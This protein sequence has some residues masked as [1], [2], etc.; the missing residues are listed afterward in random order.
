MYMGLHEF[1]RSAHFRE[2]GGEGGWGYAI[3]L[4]V[5]PAEKWSGFFITTQRTEEAL[6][7]LV[8]GC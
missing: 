5:F 1:Q 4:K 3:F 2:G 7:I 8:V 6:G